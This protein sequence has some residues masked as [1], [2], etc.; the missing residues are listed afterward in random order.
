MDLAPLGDHTGYLDSECYILSEDIGYCQS[1]G[2]K[3]LLSLGGA[4]GTYNLLN[5][6]DGENMA[7]FL[8]SAFGPPNSSWTGP[9]PFDLSTS[10]G[11]LSVDGFDFNNE[12]I[13]NV[14]RTGK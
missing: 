9:R 1:I 10:Y 3:V 2:K 6:T 14:P 7:D 13:Q 12:P 8:W 11:K 4:V 5:G